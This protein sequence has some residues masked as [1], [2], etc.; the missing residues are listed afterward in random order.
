MLTIL[1]LAP[2]AGADDGVAMRNDAG[3]ALHWKAFPVAYAVDPANPI[4]LDPDAALYEIVAAG[5]AWNQAQ[6]VGVELDFEG[7]VEAGPIGFDDEANVVSFEGSWP[8]DPEMLALTAVWSTEDG[9]VLG[10]DMQINAEDHDWSV[11]GDPDA[12]DLRNAVAHEF[13]HALGISHLGEADATMYATSTAGE[14][15]KRDLD[16]VDVAALDEIYGEGGAFPIEDPEDALR[17]CAPAAGSPI[18]SALVLAI[19]LLRRRS[20]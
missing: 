6:D 3:A 2:S 7:A 13:G 5:S 14:T 4:D 11:A 12:A 15:L 10:F 8:F 9:T 16:D 1:L 20:S 17:V 18:A 19:A